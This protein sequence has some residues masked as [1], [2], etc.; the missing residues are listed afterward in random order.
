MIPKTQ[1]GVWR[2][3]GHM[4]A[5]T[6]G[7]RV[8]HTNGGR[9]LGSAALMAGQALLPVVSRIRAAQGFVRLVASKA[10]Q[11]VSACLETLALLQ[12]RRLMTDVPRIGEIVRGVA[13]VRRPVARAAKVQNFTRGQR[14]RVSDRRAY[15]FGVSG[16]CRAHVA[17]TG[18][19]ADL[20]PHAPF[21][22]RDLPTR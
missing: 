19:M 1:V 12:I 16:R 22:H 10:R 3:S 15:L 6:I 8:R 7:S 11:P 17:F 21:C 13:P 9:R 5:G 20:A 14:T 2:D 18:A 4:A